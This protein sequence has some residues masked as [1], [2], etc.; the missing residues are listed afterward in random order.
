M[1]EKC[2]NIFSELNR[3]NKFKKFDYI[4]N[5]RRNIKKTNKFSKKLY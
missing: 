2:K 1:I 4:K 3:S 5:D